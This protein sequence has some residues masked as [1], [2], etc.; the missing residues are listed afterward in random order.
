MGYKKGRSRNI[1]TGRNP[2]PSFFFHE[3][4]AEKEEARNR[5]KN[6]CFSHF[7]DFHLEVG[8]LIAIYQMQNN[9]YICM[10]E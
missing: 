7:S 8:F 9:S 2:P 1:A 10:F 4:D 5:K 6:Y 3:P